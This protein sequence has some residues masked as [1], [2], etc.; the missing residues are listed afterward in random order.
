M[1]IHDA[2]AVGDEPAPRL[3]VVRDGT[4]IDLDAATRAVSDLL[5]ALGHD[6]ANEHLAGTPGRVADATPSC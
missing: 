6:P 3:R 4:A 5:V 1:A 2:F